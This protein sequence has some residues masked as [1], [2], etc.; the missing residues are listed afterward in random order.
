[1]GPPELMPHFKNKETKAQKW[2]VGDF[3]PI[4]DFFLSFKYAMVLITVEQQQNYASIS[5]SSIK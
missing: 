4:S 2:E 5:Q 1:M 3:N